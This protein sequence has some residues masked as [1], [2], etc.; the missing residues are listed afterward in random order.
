MLKVFWKRS[1]P[2]LEATFG[3]QSPELGQLSLH[4]LTYVLAG[5]RSVTARSASLLLRKRFLSMPR[6]SCIMAI[7]VHEQ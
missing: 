3:K 4:K 7:A 5:D 6:P 2:E 1:G